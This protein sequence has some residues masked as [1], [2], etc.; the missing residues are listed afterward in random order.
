MGKIFWLTIM[1][2]LIFVTFSHA[3]ED[4]FRQVAMHAIANGRPINPSKDIGLKGFRV[5][6]KETRVTMEG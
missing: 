2:A 6:G 5:E 3:Q 1:F 4:P